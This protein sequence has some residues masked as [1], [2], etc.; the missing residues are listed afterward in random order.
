MHLGIY[1]NEILI[2]ILYLLRP[3]CTK[4]LLESRFF[5]IVVGAA[6]LISGFRPTVH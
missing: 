3:M 1:Q 5:F 6:E 2:E 4:Y